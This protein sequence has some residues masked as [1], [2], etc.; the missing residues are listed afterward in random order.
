MAKALPIYMM[1]NVYDLDLIGNR[2][3]GYA[4]DVTNKTR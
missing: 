3:N 2:E 1:K 4:G